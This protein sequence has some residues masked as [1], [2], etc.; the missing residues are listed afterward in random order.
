MPRPC[1]LPRR[2]RRLPRWTCCAVGWNAS[3]KGYLRFLDKL[4]RI[5]D[6]VRVTATMIAELAAMRP[7][8][9]IRHLELVVN[10]HDLHDSLSDV[11]EVAARVLPD[12]ETIDFA[13]PGEIDESVLVTIP[14]LPRMFPKLTR[15]RLD[16]ARWSPAAVRTALTEVAAKYPFFEV[17]HGSNTPG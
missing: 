2:V 17:D 16:A 12:V 10:S 1:S 9:P 8:W 3:H 6:G 13:P 14:T 7:R 4:E 11:F 5:P 15:V